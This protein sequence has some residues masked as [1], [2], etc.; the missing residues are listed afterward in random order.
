GIGEATANKIIQAR[1]YTELEGLKDV[2]GIG[3]S[4][5]N[6]IVTLISL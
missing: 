4:T 6:K 5:Y 1:P 3:D 2:S